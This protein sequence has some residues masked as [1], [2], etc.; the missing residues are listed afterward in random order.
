MKIL[1]LETSCEQA[2]IALLR[3]DEVVERA[4]LGRAA[5]H[6]S[7]LLPAVRELL[8]QA[9]MSVADCDVIAFG[10]GPGAFTGV[11]L[12]CSVAQGLALG[13]DRPVAPV[14]SL[15]ALAHGVAGERIYCAQDARMNEVYVASYVRCEGGLMPVQVPICVAPSEVPVPVESGWV[16]AG[17]GFVAYEAALQARLGACLVSTH[18]QASPSAAMVARLACD[19]SLWCDPALAAPLYVRDRVALTIAERLTQGGKA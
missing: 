2:S 16:G 19:T 15:L 10:A 7:H 1:A 14:N 11:R 12:A 9:Q 6:S 4:L 3:G 18:A 13:A 17:S 8:A 5:L